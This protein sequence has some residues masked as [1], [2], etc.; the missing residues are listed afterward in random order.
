MRRRLGA[1]WAWLLLASSLAPSIASGQSA[2][3]LAILQDGVTLR[4]QGRD[5]EAHARFAEAWQREPLP[6]CAGQRAFAAQALGRWV[7]ADRFV[8]AALDAPDDDW[9]RRHRAAL[10]RAQSTIAEH[11]GLVEIVGGVAG[12][13]V[14]FD[15]EL[16]GTLPL[17]GPLRARTGTLVM[18]LRAA[19]HHSSSRRLTV[20]PRVV[21]REPG[22]L[23]ATEAPAAVAPATV[24]V[25]APTPRP[26]PPVAPAPRPPVAARWVV[27]TLAGGA[28]AGFA[29]G[30]VGLGLRE[31]AAQSFND[32]CVAGASS[33]PGCEGLQQRG[34]VGVALA[35]TG[36]AL[37]VGLGVSAVV[38]SLLRRAPSPHA[39]FAC[40]PGPGAWQCAV[41]F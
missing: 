34:D 5:A 13:E 22:E 19:G 24:V 2:E 16:V 20:E 7:E 40:A 10:E 1:T 26:P 11:I 4:Q 36:A 6:V 8:R 21:T 37:G 23:V 18:E 30:G 9:V 29:L 28:L 31:D 32:Q 14:R 17:A 12:T 25:A 3:V 35:V 39:G 38:L 27:W 33:T 15:G 41:A